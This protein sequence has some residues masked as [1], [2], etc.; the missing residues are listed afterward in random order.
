MDYSCNENK[1]YY[2]KTS[3]EGKRKELKGEKEEAIRLEG[4][5]N[6]YTPWDL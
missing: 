4:G 1:I 5:R 6:L 3:I 2:W